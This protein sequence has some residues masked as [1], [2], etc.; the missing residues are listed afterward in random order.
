MQLTINQLASLNRIEQEKQERRIEDIRI[1]L[2]EGFELNSLS[3][4][5]YTLK[6]LD[7][8]NQQYYNNNLEMRN[9]EKIKNKKG[10]GGNMNKFLNNQ[11]EIKVEDNRNIAERLLK[12]VNNNNLISKV[13]N[14]IAKSGT[15][16]ITIPVV[17]ET[18]IDYLTV[19]AKSINK[20]IKASNFLVNDILDYSEIVKEQLEM[21]V[22]KEVE[23]DIVSE[24]NSIVSVDIQVSELDKLFSSF[25][26]KYL[27]DNL[28]II[29]NSKDYKIISELKNSIGNTYFKI[30]KN[31]EGRFIPTLNNIEII[32]NDTATNITLLNPTFIGVG[33]SLVD[34]FCDNIMSTE[35]ARLGIREADLVI[36]A[37]SAI[38][39]RQAISSVKFVSVKE[40]Q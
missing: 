22:F 17:S 34:A 33:Y 13:K 9:L 38:L 20:S 36:E 11:K 40:E 28:F 3:Q 16:K 37:K 4:R 26:P 2:S 6:E 35:N 12:R 7:F 1:L 10:N 29:C 14:I 39:D 8:V 27:G 15:N 18:K 32:V 25:N 21:Q 5:G 19:Q 23:N 24:L 30:I 31:E